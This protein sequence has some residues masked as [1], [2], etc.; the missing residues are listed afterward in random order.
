MEIASRSTAGFI[1]SAVAISPHRWLFGRRRQAL[2][3]DG[4][5]AS[6]AGRRL[7]GTFTDARSPG[8]SPKPAQLPLLPM[9]Q[10]RSSRPIAD[11]SGEGLP[12][13]S[14]TTAASAY[15]SRPSIPGSPDCASS[16]SRPPRFPLC[17]VWPICS[18]SR[19]YGVYFHL[20][21]NQYPSFFILHHT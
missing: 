15:K 20:H 18:V 13:F 19:I 14:T 2:M 5:E 1:C 16:R 21:T 4:H 12:T 17:A 6:D 9:G 7:H 8:L 11:T 3:S 10:T